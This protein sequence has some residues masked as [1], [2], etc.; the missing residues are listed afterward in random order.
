MTSPPTHS[1]GGQYCFARRRLSSSV[2]VCNTPRWHIC[3]VTHQVTARF[4]GPVVSRLVRATPCLIFN[5]S[6]NTNQCRLSIRGIHWGTRC[7]VINIQVEAGEIFVIC[8]FETEAHLTALCMHSLTELV[9]SVEISSS[10]MYLL[11]AVV[12]DLVHH[13]RTDVHHCQPTAET[14]EYCQHSTHQSN[15]LSRYC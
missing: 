15:R 11:E 2:V 9:L 4:G 6:P 14:V 13:R 3:N 8:Y 7:S 5:H 12:H 1:V 10:Q